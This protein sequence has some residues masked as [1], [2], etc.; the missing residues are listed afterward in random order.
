MTKRATFTKADLRRIFM[1]AYE[2]GVTVRVT[3]EGEVV[4]NEK[5]A[6]KAVPLAA[7]EWER[8]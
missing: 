5:P 1:A 6:E 8:L 3:P 7:F 2:A 4:A